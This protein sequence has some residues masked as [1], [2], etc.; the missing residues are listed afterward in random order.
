MSNN[1]DDLRR[2]MIKNVVE[3]MDELEKGI[4]IACANLEKMVGMST[5]LH[6]SGQMRMRRDQL[7]SEYE[8]VKARLADLRL[9]NL[10]DVEKSRKAIQKARYNKNEA[11]KKADAMLAKKSSVEEG[12]YDLEEEAADEKA[13]IEAIKDA[14]TS[15]KG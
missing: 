2:L 4:V 10:P 11:L 3:Q 9:G 6:K 8:I 13:A 12:I 14:R 1:D 7:E 15:N 5:D